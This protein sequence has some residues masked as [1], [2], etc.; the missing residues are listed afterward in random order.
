MFLKKSFIKSF[1][2]NLWYILLLIKNNYF[3]SLLLL[4]AFPV[5]ELNLLLAIVYSQMNF[6][7]SNH[8]HLNN[9]LDEAAYGCLV[10]HD[11]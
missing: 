3:K 2:T 4:N 7:H 11:F 8:N 6:P 5:V 1:S 10:H 9:H